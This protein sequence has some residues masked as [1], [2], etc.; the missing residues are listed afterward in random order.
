MN[1]VNAAGTNTHPDLPRSAMATLMSQ[2]R[3]PQQQQQ[4]QQQQDYQ[5]LGIPQQ[6]EDIPVFRT[7]SSG[8]SQYF[9]G[10]G[11]F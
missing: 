5:E 7:H 6:V 9:T 8:K 1:G 4:Q 2:N 10:L 3:Q 11:V